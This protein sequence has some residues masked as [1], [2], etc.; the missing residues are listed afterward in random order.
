MG[1]G[2]RG[3]PE[4]VGWGPMGCCGDGEL[5]DPWDVGLSGG[6]TQGM[7]GG[8]GVGVGT[9]GLWGSVGCK[10]GRNPWD[11]GGGGGRRPTGCGAQ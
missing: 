7:W 3:D 6:G 2:G 9:N 10:W 5:W 1:S 4:D 8:G 11:R